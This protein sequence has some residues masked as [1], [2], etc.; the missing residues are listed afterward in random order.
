LGSGFRDG[1]LS[2]SEYSDLVGNFLEVKRKPHLR[3]HPKKHHC[4]KVA[5]PQALADAIR[6]REKTGLIFPNSEGKPDQHLLRHL[7][8]L[9]Q[10][11]PMH[12]ELHKL[13]KTW[14]T[15]L[16]MAGMPVHVLQKLL[17]HKSLVTTQ[18]YLAD[19]DLASGQMSKAIEAASYVPKPIAVTKAA[20]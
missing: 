2:H 4:R 3:W 10:G 16:A 11:S 13:R 17:G 14:A 1:E 5:V 9:T 18:K 6:A 12:T 19:V 15:R 7:Q 20:A 8:A